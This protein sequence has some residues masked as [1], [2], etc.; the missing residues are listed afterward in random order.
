MKYKTIALELL[1]QDL[2]LYRRLKASRTL[3]LAL[4]QCSAALKASHESWMDRIARQRPGSEGN[5]VSGEA[6]ECALLEIQALLPTAS[7]AT[8][9]EPPSLDAVMAFLRRH[10]PPA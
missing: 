3:L 1:Q 4:D 8:G 5:Q 9:E 2:E 6:L 10:T 7:E